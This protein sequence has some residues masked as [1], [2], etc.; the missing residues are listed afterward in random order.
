M[1]LNLKLV[2]S[3]CL[4]SYANP[5]SF[6]C[7]LCYTAFYIIHCYRIKNHVRS[8]KKYDKSFEKKVVIAQL[9]IAAFVVL[10]SL[11][12][13]LMALQYILNALLGALYALIFYACC[14]NFENQISNIMKHTTIMNIVLSALYVGQQ[15][16]RVLH[17]DHPPGVRVRRVHFVPARQ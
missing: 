12:L 7:Q 14:V 13:F 6:I 10:Y 11:I 2:T 16:I 5:S 3:V 8:F 17:F 1:R 9:T 4:P 15:A